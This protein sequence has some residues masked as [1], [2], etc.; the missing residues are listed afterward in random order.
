MLWCGRAP[1]LTGSGPAWSTRLSSFLRIPKV[2]QNTHT[3]RCRTVNDLAVMFRTA[4]GRCWL[5]TIDEEGRHRGSYLGKMGSEF[6]V[7]AWCESKGIEFRQ[8]AGGVRTNAA[9]VSPCPGAQV[10]HSPPAVVG[11][12]GTDAAQIHLRLEPVRVERVNL[13][14]PA[15]GLKA[16]DSVC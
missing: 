3:T 13:A 4:D 1:A 7:R 11:Q 15:L 8:S 16:T 10:Q 6:A 2:R 14:C 12:D 9:R 5:N